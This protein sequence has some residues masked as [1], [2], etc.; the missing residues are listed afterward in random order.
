MKNINL[1]ITSTEIEGKEARQIIFE[2]DLSI[3]SAQLIK[4]KILEVLETFEN[5]KVV[6]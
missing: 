1:N 5:L 6:V 3:Q 4:D 2:G